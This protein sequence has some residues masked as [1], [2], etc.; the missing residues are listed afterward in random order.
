M[1]LFVI[2]IT[3][4]RKLR[5][6]LLFLICYLSSRVCFF[7]HRGNTHKMTLFLLCFYSLR[8]YLDHKDASN[9]FGSKDYTSPVYHHLAV[10][11]WVCCN[12]MCEIPA[13]WKKVT[14]AFVWLPSGNT[15]RYCSFS[16][17]LL[18]HAIHARLSWNYLLDCSTT[19]FQLSVRIQL[20]AFVADV[21]VTSS[22]CQSVLI[23]LLSNLCEVVL[24]NKTS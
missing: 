11:R 12:I 1:C 18:F 9:M 14:P 2:H 21:T 22:M 3:I 24:L 16:S 19:F 23:V 20:R 8:G 5:I 13:L 15:V 10:R 17:L 4:T 6:L 7:E